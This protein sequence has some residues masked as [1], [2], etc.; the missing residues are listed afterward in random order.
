[1]SGG[2]VAMAALLMLAA[3]GCG[4]IAGVF[5]AF[6]TFVMRALAILPQRDGIAAMQAINVAV[7][8]PLFLGVFMGSAAVSVIAAATAFAVAGRATMIWTLVGALLYVMGT[9]SV[10]MTFN[11]PL[12]NQLERTPTDDPAAGR[13]WADYLRRWTRWNHVRT[14]AAASAMLAFVLALWVNR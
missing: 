6:S 9:F 4:L 14:I 11:V 12:N 13:V 10:T 2:E 8:N 5:Y 1:M 7:I 3:V